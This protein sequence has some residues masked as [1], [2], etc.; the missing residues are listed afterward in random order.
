MLLL[1]ISK[2]QRSKESVHTF[3]GSLMKM[4]FILRKMYHIFP[5]PPFLFSYRSSGESLF[6]CGFGL[7]G[8]RLIIS[9]ILS[10]TASRPNENLSSKGHDNKHIKLGS[11][12]SSC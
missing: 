9:V 7:G 3:L 2:Q 12:C 5:P 4:R 1:L 6:H 10:R 8:G 11:E